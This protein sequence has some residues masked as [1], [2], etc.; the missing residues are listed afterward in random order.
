MAGQQ[1][2]DILSKQTEI[3]RNTNRQVENVAAS[4]TSNKGGSKALKGAKE[5]TGLRKTSDNFSLMHMIKVF[6]TSLLKLAFSTNTRI[7]SRY[8]EVS[9]DIYK[10]KDI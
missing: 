7:F 5:A 3:L 10:R 4:S 2:E 1:T 8:V 6:L 9:P